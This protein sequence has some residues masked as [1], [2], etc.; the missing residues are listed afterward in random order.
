MTLR[1]PRPALI[2]GSVLSIACATGEPLPTGNN[3][4]DGVIVTDG[5]LWCVR[6]DGATYTIEPNTPQ[7]VYESGG[8]P[9]YFPKGCSC[10]S[11]DENTRLVSLLLDGVAE[12]DLSED[13]DLQA[14]RNLAYTLAEVY[15]V[16]LVPPAADSSTCLEVIDR[17]DNDDDGL[18]PLF[19]E[20]D[21]GDCSASESI[22]GG[23]MMQAPP[24]DG[25]ADYYSINSVIT[26]SAGEYTIDQ[27]FFHDMLSNPGWLL[28]DDARIESTGTGG[29]RFT[30]VS[31]T[32]VAY[33]LGL[34]TNDVIGSLNSIPLTG[35]DA[36][37][38]AHEQLK[39]EKSLTF[40]VIRSGVPVTLLY[41]IG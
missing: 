28:A 30:N 32:D 26:F 41:E 20:G 36:A 12:V 9:D 7:P 6:T 11:P 31:S 1:I 19:P 24:T 39:S 40:V 23:S 38:A 2:L 27:T 16:D 3:G 15:C 33:K 35:W 4:T 13:E 14:I 10:A 22:G 21:Q 34:R 18:T 29:W 17:L 5:Y 25:Y 8:P 37:I